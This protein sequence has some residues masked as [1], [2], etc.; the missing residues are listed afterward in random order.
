M[1]NK[2]DLA[3]IKAENRFCYILCVE[4]F[5]FHILF[6]FLFR[7]LVTDPETGSTDQGDQQQNRKQHGKTKSFINWDCHG[8]E[9]LSRLVQ[10]QG[11][12]RNKD[13]GRT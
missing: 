12:K 7:H 10:E 5:I 11:I 3:I 8:I 9:L 1:G 2:G 6:D 13:K 4:E